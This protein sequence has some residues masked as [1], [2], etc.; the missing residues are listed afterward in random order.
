[1]NMILL[2]VNVVFISIACI[3]GVVRYFSNKT[4]DR[5]PKFRRNLMKKFNEYGIENEVKDE[6]LYVVKKGCNMKFEFSNG[7]DGVV[8]VFMDSLLKLDDFDID[9]VGELFVERRI[10][11]G[12]IFGKARFVQKRLLSIRNL[13][14]VRKVDNMINLT[15]LYVDAVNSIYDDLYSNKEQLEARF[16]EK[17]EQNERKIGFQ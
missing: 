3:S 8:N 12:L 15:D 17:K 10:N 13:I 2:V 6:M 4:I 1:M 11:D 16:G 9:S 7:Y 5:V 14:S